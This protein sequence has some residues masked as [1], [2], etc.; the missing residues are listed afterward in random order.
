M[1]KANGDGA[2]ELRTDGPLPFGDGLFERLADGFGLLAGQNAV[3]TG[4]RD[5]E[6][7]IRDAT[8]LPGRLAQLLGQ[9]RD[10]DRFRHGEDS[11][12]SKLDTC[13]ASCHLRG[14]GV[15]EAM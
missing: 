9:L 6:E 1:A 7:L 2:A 13:G 15:D 14:A 3:Q 11:A 8:H 10:G 12:G 4:P 5:L